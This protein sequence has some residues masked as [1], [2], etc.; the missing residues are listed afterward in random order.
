MEMFTTPEQSVT[1][2]RQE[3]S[4]TLEAVDKLETNLTKSLCQSCGASTLMDVTLH[5]R[6]SK[7]IGATS[8]RSFREQT[9]NRLDNSCKN[10]QVSYVR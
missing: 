7:F 3:K 5:G 6:L 2:T 10:Y 8:D 1:T 4:P 9:H